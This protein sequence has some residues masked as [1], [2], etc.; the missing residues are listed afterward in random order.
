MCHGWQADIEEFM[1]QLER[2]K[3]AILPEMYRYAVQTIV[4]M[5]HME[6]SNDPRVSKKMKGEDQKPSMVVRRK[7]LVKCKCKSE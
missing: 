3:A 7:K 6:A 4:S 5:D 1:S 2:D